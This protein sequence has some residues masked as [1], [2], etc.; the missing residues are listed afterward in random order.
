MELNSKIYECRVMHKRLN[1][2]KNGFIYNI[3]MFCIDL[4]ELPTLSKNNFLFSYNRLNLFSFFDKDHSKNKAGTTK[5]KVIEYL[6]SKGMQVSNDCRVLLVT[7]PRI[8]G[9]IFNPVSFYFIFD[10]TSKAV[11]SIAEVSNTFREMKLYLIEEIVNNRFKL[12]T[13]KHFY[14][15][16]FS[17]LNLDFDFDFAL[18][19]NLLD[20]KINEFEG[21]KK[22]LISSVYGVPKHFTSGRLIWLAIKYPLL[23][24]KVMFLI[25][26]QALKLKLKGLKHY[27]KKDNPQLQKDLIR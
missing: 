3:F 18:P 20:I 12:R 8:A 22:I 9:Y 26:W 6:R 14:V 17:S 21:E 27:P 13:P 1:P 10:K 15:S 7:M 19:E 11:C 16:P 4:D 25:H 24:L 5:L 2:I 23:T